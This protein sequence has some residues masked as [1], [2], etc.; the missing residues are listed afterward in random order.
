[1]ISVLLAL[2]L[3]PVVQAAAEPP[4]E[5]RVETL[6][7]RQLVGAPREGHGALVLSSG[8]ER[9]ELPL[10]EVALIEVLGGALRPDTPG[11]ASG[12]DLVALRGTAVGRQRLF[13][14]LVGG[15]EFGLA[16]QLAGAVRVQLPFER[17][18]RVLPEVDRPLDRLLALPGGGADDRLWRR[19]PDGSLDSLTGVLESVADD[20]GSLRFRSALGALDFTRAEVLALVLADES[21]RPEPVEG[22][23]VLVALHD[24]TRF[25]A[26]WTGIDAEGRLLFVTGFAGSLALPVASLASLLRQGG[27]AVPLAALPVHEVAEHPSFGGPQ[28]VLYGWQSDLSVSGRPLR[29]GGRARASGLGVHAHCTLTLRLPEGARALRVGAGLCDEV[30]EIPARASVAFEILVDGVS[31]AG[32]LRLIEGEAPLVLRVD[33]LADCRLVQLRV[34]DGGDDDAGDRAAW[35][36]GLVLLANG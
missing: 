9:S 11:T 33:G 34:D 21:P 28:D 12:T 13:G 8:G 31:R 6:D 20:G 36:D 24:G 22:L 23:A 29:V 19:R 30:G 32:P 16:L 4:I 3:V 10:A 7:G 1:M 25:S 5:W 27:G 2:L 35:F 26:G 17:I 14:Q 18:E 15:D